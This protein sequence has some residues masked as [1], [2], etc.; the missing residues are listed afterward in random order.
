LVNTRTHALYTYTLMYK[1]APTAHH[2]PHLI[3]LVWA[4]SHL[5]TIH[6]VV[7]EG[8][9]RNHQGLDG[10]EAVLTPQPFVGHRD[11]GHEGVFTPNGAY[12]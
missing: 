5:R 3:N 2:T 4:E 8:G 12:V 11:S 9:E 10:D 1:L 7:H 6:A